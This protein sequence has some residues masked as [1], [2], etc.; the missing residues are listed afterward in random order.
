VLRKSKLS[1]H[2]I[3]TQHTLPSCRFAGNWKCTTRHY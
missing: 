2:K 3:W 1:T